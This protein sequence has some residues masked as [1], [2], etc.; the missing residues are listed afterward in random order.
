MAALGVRQNK[1]MGHQLPANEM[2]LYHR[3]DEVLHYIWD[4]IG[5]STTPSARDEYYSY[6]PKVYSMLKSTSDGQEIKN[7][8]EQIETDHMGLG[9][10]FGMR[11]RLEQV[12]SLLL[13]YRKQTIPPNAEP[14]AAAQPPAAFLK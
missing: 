3:T 6:L 14:C 9:K 7:Y 10:R 8:L 4:P 12:V 2:K 5:I 1:K 11:K 13:E